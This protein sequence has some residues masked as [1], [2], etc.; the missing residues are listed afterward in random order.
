MTNR[1]QGNWHRAKWSARSAGGG[2]A[3]ALL[4]G[5]VGRSPLGPE[6][7]EIN[8]FLTD[9][10]VNGHVWAWTQNQV[11][12]ALLFLYQQVLHVTLEQIQGS[13]T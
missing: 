6:G 3:A 10:A 12:S 1:S 4:L 2:L 7:P 5:G 9:L 8:Q 11:F 13:H